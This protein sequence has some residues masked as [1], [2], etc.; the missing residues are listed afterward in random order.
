MKTRYNTTF[1][2]LMGLFVGL[3]SDDIVAQASSS[4]TGV[5]H[6]APVIELPN[7]EGTRYVSLKEFRGKVVYVDFWASWCAP[8]RRSFPHF[9][10]LRAELGQYGFELI[11]INMDENRDDA[12]KF[13]KKVPVDFPILLD[14]QGNSAEVFGLTGMPTS[15]LIDQQGIIR[16][17]HQGFKEKDIKLITVKINELLGR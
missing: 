9:Q 3:S 17:V 4:S 15:Y 14:P 1:I 10:K 13:L 12:E 2:F 11:G 7:F 6:L 16:W 5:G 8:C